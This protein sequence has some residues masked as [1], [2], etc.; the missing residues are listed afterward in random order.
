MRTLWLATLA[1]VAAHKLAD[2]HCARPDL[3]SAVMTPAGTS[4][5]A[6]GGVLVEAEVE[7]HRAAIGSEDA[8]NPTWRFTDGTKTYEP[9][10]VTLAPGLVLYRPPAGTTGTLTLVDDKTERGN[11]TRTTDT[12][13]PLAAPAPK[14]LRF[15]T[16]EL[17]HGGSV[18]W[19][20]ATFTTAAPVG[21]VAVVVYRV[22]KKGNVARSWMPIEAGATTGRVAGTAGRCSPGIPGEIVSKV[23]DKVVLAWVDA[24]GRLSKVSKPIT[25]SR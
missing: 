24:S 23:G 20:D 8:L 4:V 6:D 12:P 5:A 14:K 13:A 25:V 15:V 17:M 16:S 19:I 21:A 1:L 18:Q 11:V 10:L 22:T 3:G 7:F 2:A 9:E